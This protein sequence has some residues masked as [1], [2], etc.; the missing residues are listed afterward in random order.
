MNVLF[1]RSNKN[2]GVIHLEGGAKNGGPPMEF[3]KKPLSCR[4]LKDFLKR[5]NGKN[6]E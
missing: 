6:K 5:V 4:I 3:M 2:S 1:Y